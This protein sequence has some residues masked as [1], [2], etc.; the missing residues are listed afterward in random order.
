[1]SGSFVAGDGD[2]DGDAAGSAMGIGTAV[3]PPLDVPDGDAGG[4]VVAI[5]FGSSG[6]GP[7]AS[8]TINVTA[9]AVSAAIDPNGF[10]T[11]PPGWLDR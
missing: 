2:A 6:A 11:E 7:A 3:M 10:R 4:G 5:A 1:V 8:A 9:S